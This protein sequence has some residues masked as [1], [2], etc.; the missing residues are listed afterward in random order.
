VSAGAIPHFSDSWLTKSESLGRQGAA[1]WLLGNADARRR[2]LHEN[3][4]PPSQSL[5]ERTATS[6]QLRHRGASMSHT[7]KTD[8]ALFV[9]AFIASAFV[10][11]ADTSLAHVL[12][13]LIGAH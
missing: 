10:L 12:G 6:L 5:P 8:L 3:A 2:A 9:A 4:M 13:A 7:L 1:P 11:G